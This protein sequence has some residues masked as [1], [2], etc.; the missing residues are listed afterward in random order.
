MRLARR[1]RS[2]RSDESLS[3]TQLAALSTLDLHGAMTPT[4][5][6]DH[7]RVQ[8][9]SMTRVI[10]GLE[11][12]QLVVRESHPTDRRQVVIALTPDAHLLIAEDRRRKEAWL[13]RQLAGLSSEER[14]VLRA[15]APLLER[16]SLS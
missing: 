9:P 8:P 11:Q 12:R 6:A 13:G 2:Q 16:L 5:L 14:D 10:A 1:L 7:E 15:A 4:A 3:L